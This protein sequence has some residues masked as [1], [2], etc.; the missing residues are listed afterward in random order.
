MQALMLLEQL[1]SPDAEKARRSLAQLR[2]KMGAE[3]FDAAL[4]E[5]GVE[6]G[7][8]PEAEP[9]TLEQMID[10]IVQNT[11]VVLTVAP[12]QRAEWQASLGQA[13]AQQNNDAGF[14]AFLGAVQQVL[15]GTDP[16]EV[17]VALEEGYAEAWQRLVEA[18]QRTRDS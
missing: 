5:L 2:A 9:M 1:G 18:L 15:E 14:A 6:V 11:V 12:E 4:A 7:G 13:Q 3:A 17:D 10:V 8:E 16:A